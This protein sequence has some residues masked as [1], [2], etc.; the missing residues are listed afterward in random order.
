MC[1]IFRALLLLGPRA[2]GFIWRL[3]APARWNE[4]FSTFLW[5][6]LGLIVL[7][8]LTL[9]YDVVEPGGVAGFDQV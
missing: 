2:G 7:P 3:A 1:C 6:L 8:W 4:A 5:P 9:I